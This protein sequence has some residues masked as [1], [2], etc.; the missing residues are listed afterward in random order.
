MMQGDG[1]FCAYKGTG[2]G[3][4]KGN[5]MCTGT[6]VGGNAPYFAIMQG[7]GNFVVYKGTGP[8]DN[9]GYVWGSMQANSG[10]SSG[11][12]KFF[13]DA[14]DWFKGAGNTIANAFKGKL[15]S[16]QST[17]TLQVGGAAAEVTVTGKPS[18]YTSIQSGA[19]QVQASRTNGVDGDYVDAFNRKTIFSVKGT[20]AGAV[21]LRF[22]NGETETDV[23]FN[24]LPAAA[25]APAFARVGAGKWF[26]TT[27]QYMREGDVLSAENKSHFVIMQGDGNFCEYRGSGPGDNKGNV[28]CMP[29][30]SSGNGSYFAA[31]QGDGNFCVYRG[32]GPAD[33][34]GVIACSNSATFPGSYF[35]A[36]QGDGNIVVYR[37]T[38]PA[39]NKG[40][41]W[42][43]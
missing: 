15:K 17:G 11:A 7:D 5:I 28:W 32:T 16:S 2:P 36:M 33:N 8:G 42:Q 19:G 23:S 14:G 35:L 26:M 18:V 24:V 34:K 4:N 29:G 31:V 10:G 37:G 30:R 9:K 6:A 39:D 3:D 13:S 21:T 12:S 22:T 38:G 20:R 27:N 40:L 25:P 43:R 1:N 41:V